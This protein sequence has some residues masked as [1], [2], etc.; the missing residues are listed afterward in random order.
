MRIVWSIY[1]L[2]SLWSWK[3]PRDKRFSY[4]VF[5]R[6]IASKVTIRFLNVNWCKLR[7]NLNLHSNFRGFFGYIFIK[8]ILKL[9]LLQILPSF[10]AKRSSLLWNCVES[11]SGDRVDTWLLFRLRL[12]SQGTTFRTCYPGH[13]A[14][15]W[16]KVLLVIYF[17]ERT[18]LIELN[19]SSSIFD[20]VTLHSW[21]FMC[22]RS[23]LWS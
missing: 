9:F 6:F 3:Y 12:C 2:F 19:S 4:T 23:E 18:G 13:F 10:D 22:L 16:F 1:R 15:L 11:L 17:L 14:Y 8:S 7:S 5:V 21:F 20:K